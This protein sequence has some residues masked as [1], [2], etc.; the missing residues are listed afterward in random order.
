M[1]VMTITPTV[2]LVARQPV[3]WQHLGWGGAILLLCLA[4]ILIG[5]PPAVAAAKARRQAQVGMGEG[6]A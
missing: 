6:D 2:D 3:G 5:L 4:P 1:T